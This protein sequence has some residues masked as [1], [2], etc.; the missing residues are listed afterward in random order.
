MHPAVAQHSFK[1]NCRVQKGCPAPMRRGSVKRT[2]SRLQNRRLK[3]DFSKLKIGGGRAQRPRG[4]GV[5]A[6]GKKNEPRSLDPTPPLTSLVTDGAG[7]NRPP[8]RGGCRGGELTPRGSPRRRGGAVSAPAVWKE[9]LGSAL[10]ASCD[11]HGP[12]MF[13]FFFSLILPQV[14]RNVYFL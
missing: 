5:G 12:E 11:T 13:L 14:L 10:I 3:G 2:F 1:M 6:V 4:G 8:S 7:S 9:P